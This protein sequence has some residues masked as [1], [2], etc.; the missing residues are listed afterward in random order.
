MRLMSASSGGVDFLEDGRTKS[1]P[2]KREFLE[3][4]SNLVLEDERIQ[5][6]QRRI[7]FALRSCKEAGM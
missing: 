2:G 1:E 4:E 7:G 6:E 5:K 3:E